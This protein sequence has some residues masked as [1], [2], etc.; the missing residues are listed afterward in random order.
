MSGESD[1]QTLT[2]AFTSYSFWPNR[3]SS[4]FFSL[5][6]EVG[7]GEC[8]TATRRRSRKWGGKLTAAIQTEHDEA[9]LKSHKLHIGVYRR[10]ADKLGVDASYV[11]RV[12]MGNRKALEDS[13]CPLG[14]ASQDTTYIKVKVSPRLSG[15]AAGCRCYLTAEDYR[16]LPNSKS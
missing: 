7:R 13:S 11:S 6:S 5:C 16:R 10:V 14:R 15:V 2:S 12:A 8:G 9:L 3:Q 1:V 4:A